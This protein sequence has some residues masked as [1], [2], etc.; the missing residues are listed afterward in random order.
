MSGNSHLFGSR[1]HPASLVTET[2]WFIWFFACLV[3]ALE[4]AER[5]T[6]AERTRPARNEASPGV[7]ERVAH[8]PGCAHGVQQ[9]MFDSSG[10]PARCRANCLLS[11]GS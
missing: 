7:F 10:P 11:L 8:R 2:D 6:C 3:H 4:S 1:F 5:A 9:P